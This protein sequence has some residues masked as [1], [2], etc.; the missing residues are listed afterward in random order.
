MAGR[1]GGAAFTACQRGDQ[2]EPSGGGSPGASSST[3]GPVIRYWPVSQRPRS[4]SAQRAEQNGSSRA[5]VASL[6]Q[7]GQRGIAERVGGLA[8]SV[9][10]QAPAIAGQG[11]VNHNRR[12]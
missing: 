2:A 8:R 6:P 9:M 7:T 4:T 1:Q 12:K 11:R 5:V 10:R 3:A